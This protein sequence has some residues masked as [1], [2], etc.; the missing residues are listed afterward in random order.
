MKTL[1]W[2]PCVVKKRPTSYK[3]LPLDFLLCRRCLRLRLPHGH[4]QYLRHH[5]HLRLHPLPHFK[6]SSGSK[7]NS[8]SVDNGRQ[9]RNQETDRRHPDQRSLRGRLKGQESHSP[10]LLRRLRRLPR[11]GGGLLV[12]RQYRQH[13]LYLRGSRRH[14][15]R[16]RQYYH[17]HTQHTCHHLRHRE[18]VLSSMVMDPCWRDHDFC[19]GQ[20]PL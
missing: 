10:M 4:Q 3:R 20:H 13:H 2:M 8:S 9:D 12:P 5:K 18:P 19:Q 15:H 17:P 14:R 6:Y 16:Q 11:M 1:S 7:S